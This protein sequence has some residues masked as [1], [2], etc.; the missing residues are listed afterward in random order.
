MHFSSPHQCMYCSVEVN[1]LAT[2]GSDISGEWKDHSTYVR[3]SWS[4][5]TQRSVRRSDYT[6]LHY[7]KDHTYVLVIFDTCAH[8][9]VHMYCISYVF[10]TLC[11]IFLHPIRTYQAPYTHLPGTLYALTRHPIRTYQAPYT[12]LPGTLYALTRHP[13]RT[14]QAPY[15]HLPGT[16]YAL[17]RHPICTYQA[18][19]THLPGT[20]YA[21]TR[22]SIRTYSNSTGTI[23]T[24]IDCSSLCHSLKYYT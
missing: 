8:V 21:L 22:H 19:Y 20:L 13:I 7:C 12:H 24:Y 1:H 3:T 6:G 10:R 11:E 4:V 16:L 14:Y 9:H 2:T 23:P 5:I 15:T 18:P 17:T